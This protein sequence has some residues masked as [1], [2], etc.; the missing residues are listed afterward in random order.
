[1]N[2]PTRIFA[3]AVD[4]K[5]LEQFRSA[6]EQD[7]S[8]AGALMPDAHVGYTL[9]IGGVIATQ[10]V[11]L[12]SWVGY[13]IGCGMCALPTSFSAEE[14]RTNSR[15]IF[16]DIYKRIPVGFDVNTRPVECALN[17]DDLTPIGRKAFNQRKGFRVIGTLGGGNHFI[18]IGQDETGQAWVILHSGSRGVGHGIAT[19]Y[20]RMASGTGRASEGHF[21][22]RTDSDAGRAYINDM[23]W[24]LELALANRKEIMRRVVAAL[25]Q[26]TPGEA[27]WSRLINR[28]HN[29]AEEKEGLWIHRKGATHAE[30]GML[31]VVPGNMRDGSFIVCGKGNPAALW[32]S[33]HGAGR[34]MGRKQAL[35]SLD[36]AEFRETMQGITARV[37]ARTL[38]ESPFAYKDIFE[39][40][41]LQSDLVE[42]CRHITPII[43]IKA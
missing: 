22:F 28:N 40:M 25:A 35:R 34:V 43:N 4:P 9:P 37:D 27:D 33:A 1:M 30:K 41:R 15:A 19:E 24:T 6:M 31:G 13:D 3:E 12:P 23:N 42:V 29:H 7:F 8:V 26:H 10:D 21:G 39:V 17:P 20:M 32:S 16:Q 11:V 5:A 38:D 18:E 2:K 14:I 36:P